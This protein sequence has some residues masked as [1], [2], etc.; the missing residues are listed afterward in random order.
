MNKLSWQKNKAT[1]ENIDQLCCRRI[2][3][4]NVNL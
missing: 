3:V 1:I 4:K 2:A